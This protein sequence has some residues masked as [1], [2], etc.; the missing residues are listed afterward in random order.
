METVRTV[1]RFSLPQLLCLQF[2]GVGDS[3]GQPTW[4]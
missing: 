1:I 2:H 4:T 3:L